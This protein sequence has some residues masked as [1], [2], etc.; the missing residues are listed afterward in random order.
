[1]KKLVNVRDID[2]YGIMQ[3]DNISYYPKSQL[4]HYTRSL[5]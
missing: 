4:K 5:D 2:E 1:M 3:K